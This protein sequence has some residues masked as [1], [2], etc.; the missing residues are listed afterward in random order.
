[1][2]L[3]SNLSKNYNTFNV[4]REVYIRLKGLYL[5]ETYSGDQVITIGGKIKLADTR[6]V[7]AIT[8]NQL[9]NHFFRSSI[10][11]T[12]VPKVV[13]LGGLNNADIG[14]FVTIEKAIFPLD[15]VGKPYVDPQEDFDTKR[16]IQTCQGLGLVAAFIETSSFSNFSNESLPKGGGTISAVV[17]KD[18]NGKFT[19][20]VLNSTEDVKMDG[21]RCA[22]L[23]ETDFPTVL[24]TQDF[25]TTSGTVRI[26]NWTNY[27]E[28][29][30]K[31]WTS[32]ADGSSNSRAVKIGSFKSRNTSTISWLITEGVNLDT[33]TQ[34]FLSFETSNSFSDGSNLEALISTDWDG[35]TAGISTAIWNVLPARIVDD[36]VDNTIWIHS[37]YIDLSNYKGTAYIAFKY[38]G[39]GTE[40]F[41]GTFELDNILIRG[42]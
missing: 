29:G 6:E 24:L 39:N 35:T 10:T 41:D 22:Q 36:A 16:K 4:G 30:T 18:F 3:P 12:I 31:S 15:L 33:T 34:E 38:T 40:A 2:K 21:E 20:L 25:E 11:E 19:V 42:K 1:L 28:A 26:P 37:T 8:N 13:T 9:P 14:T 27:K 23:S 5:G 32:Y 7:E 17:S